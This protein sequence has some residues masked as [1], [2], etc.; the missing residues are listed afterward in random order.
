MDSL[1]DEKKL[2]RYTY[3]F[4]LICFANISLLKDPFDVGAL[5]MF[6]VICFLMGYSHFILRK[7]FPDG[8]KYLLVFAC[9]LSSIGIV[10]LYRINPS[11]AVRQ[12]VW[13]I[14]GIAVFILIVV[15]LPELKI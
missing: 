12:I 7:F 10:I 9:I 6:A 5:V 1:K 13:F 14:G 2:L 11:Y 15:L 4:C 3:F 8:D